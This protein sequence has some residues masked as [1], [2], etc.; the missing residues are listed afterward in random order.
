MPE[1]VKLLVRHALIGFGL[2]AVMVASLWLCNVGN[3]AVLASGPDGYVAVIMLTA[4]TGFTFASAQMGIAVMRAG[5]EDEDDDTPGSLLGAV[6]N[7]LLA[8]IHVHRGR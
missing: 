7:R 2:A 3:F 4:F 6:S 5:K 1:L 8:F